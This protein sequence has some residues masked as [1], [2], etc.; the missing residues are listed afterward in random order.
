MSGIPNCAFEEAST[1]RTIEW[2]I[3]SVWI[4]TSMSSKGTP[5][6]QCASIT[7]SPLFIR[8][9]ELIVTFAPIF[10]VGCLSAC[11]GVAFA[12]ASRSHVRNGPPDAVRTNFLDAR[13]CA[14]R[15][16][17]IFTRRVFRLTHQTLPDGAMLAIYGP[18]AYPLRRASPVTISPAMTTPLYWRGRPLCPLRARR[19]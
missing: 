9:A 10:Q 15:A 13:P 4:T 14:A 19:V 6:S 8:L 1:K 3:L 7:S 16:S 5:K 11:C 17:R 2:I 12:V 18:D